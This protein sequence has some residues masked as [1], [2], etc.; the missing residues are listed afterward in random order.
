MRNIIQQDGLEQLEA[1]LEHMLMKENA[2]NVPGKPNFQHN[3]I[4]YLKEVHSER[5]HPS[6]REEAFLSI[7]QFSVQTDCLDQTVMQGAHL[8][9]NSLRHNPN[10]QPGFL[11]IIYAVALEIAIKMN[12]QMIL[13]LE[14]VASLF[15]NRFN[16]SMLCNLEKHI[17]TLNNFRI[18][19]A[20]PLDFALH[21]CFLMGETLT[22]KN[23]GMFELEPESILNLAVSAMHFAMSQYEISRMKYSSIAVASICHVLQDINDDF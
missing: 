14:D 3:P 21:F 19:V 13:S 4:D 5:I 8:A 16:V 20:T 1:N 9:D 22:V 15:E 12:E 7:L 23:N 11:R 6:L 18:N 10:I 2:E 17:L